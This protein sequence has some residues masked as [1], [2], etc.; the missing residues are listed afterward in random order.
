MNMLPRLPF[1]LC[2]CFL[3]YCGKD[4]GRDADKSGP[5]AEPSGTEAQRA[6]GLETPS[7]NPTPRPPFRPLRYADGFS[8]GWRGD[9]TVLVVRNPWQGSKAEFTYLLA[10]GTSAPGKSDRRNTVLIRLPAARVVTLTTTNL[11]QLES[12]HALDALVGVGGGRYVCSPEI[13]AR[14][15]SGRIRDVGEDVRLDLET[16]MALRPDLIFTFVVGN[17]SDGGLAKLAETGIPAVIEASYMEESPLGRAEWIKFTAAFLG[18]SA[19]ADSVFAEV[20]SAYRALA[21]LARKAAHKPTVMVGAP[22]GG[23]WWMAGGRTYVAR[24]LADAGGDYLWGADTTRGSLN[25]D[26]EAVLGR[27]SGADFWLNAGAWKDLGDARAKDPRNAL[28]KS[29]RSGRVYANDAGRC[30]G[31]GQ[32]FFETG[33]ARPDWILADLISILHPELLPG[34]KLHWYRRLAGPV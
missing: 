33:A 28:F 23:V 20:D 7:S 2:A 29:W 30:E 5:R 1:I 9:T 8:L 21:D 32:D 15:R 26:M 27:A 18:K 12:L 14:L 6:A 17:S 10:P 16:V 22:F 31:G 11:R 3:A 19:E 25:L 4:V 34:H 24:L 13:R